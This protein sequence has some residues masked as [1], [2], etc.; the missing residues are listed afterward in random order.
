MVKFIDGISDLDVN[1]ITEFI[2]VN[3]PTSK[4]L[5]EAIMDDVNDVV[6]MMNNNHCLGRRA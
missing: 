4:K 1:D 2:H 6:D 3:D 5:T